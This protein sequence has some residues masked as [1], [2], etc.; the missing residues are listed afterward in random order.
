MR[1]ASAELGVAIAIAVCLAPA[2]ARAERCGPPVPW[3]L[4]SASGETWLAD[5]VPSILADLRAGTHS[6]GIAACVAEESPIGAPGAV[7]V[8]TAGARSVLIEASGQDGA[9][10]FRREVDVGGYSTQARS[11]TIAS[12]V[13]EALRSHWAHLQRLEAPLDE[14]GVPVE[15]T[16]PEQEPIE[17]P[18]A[19]GAPTPEGCAP[20]PCPPEA[21][22]SLAL[23]ATFAAEGFETEQAWLAGAIGVR[24]RAIEHLELELSLEGGAAIP[25]STDLGSVDGRR[26]LGRLHV[27][28]TPMRADEGLRVYGVV[29]AT[30]GGAW[31]EGGD[32]APGWSARAAGGWFVA[33]HGGAA[34]A[35]TLASSIELTL[36]TEIGFALRGV[37]ATEGE[38]QLTGMRGV[39]GTGR[40]G[41]VFWLL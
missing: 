31:L 10:A 28:L 13:D 14:E 4:V 38:R 20:I 39:L 27:S 23:S 26:L 22:R 9:V 16:E 7:V 2:L 36:S 12:N 11:V 40:V 32:A 19:C 21:P 34:I 18:A 29:G 1:R 5:L 15:P 41:L 30:A 8:L 25:A 17:C 24:L 3:V 37:Y 33:V 6:R 35:I